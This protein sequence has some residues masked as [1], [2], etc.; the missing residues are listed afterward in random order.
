MHEIWYSAEFS[1]GFEKL[2]AK[3]AR[4]NSEAKYLLGLIGKATQK[5]ALDIEAGIKIPR[6]Q[7]PKEYA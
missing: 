3:A 4:G 7:W 1:G 6:K 5:L 2:K